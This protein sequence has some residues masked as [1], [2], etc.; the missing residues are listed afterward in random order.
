MGKIKKNCIHCGTVVERY[1]SQIL[2]T[3]YCSRACRSEYHKKYHTE[4]F[5]CHF[6]GKEKRVRKANFNYSGNNFCSRKCKDEWQKTGLK[7]EANPFYNKQHT[8]ETRIK[9]SKTKKSMNLTGE[10]AHNYNT[11]AVECSECGKVT[12]KIGY[13]LKRSKFHFC[14]IECHGKWKSKYN[15]GENNPN[16]NP[17]LTEFERER[18]RHIPG[19][20]EFVRNVLERDDFTCDICRQKGG[21]LNAHHLNG[22]D[23]DKGNRTNIDNGITLCEKCHTDFHKI[24]GYGNNTK[25]QYI[26]YK[27]TFKV[28]EKESV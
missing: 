17:E 8:I 26:D 27:N 18:E 5:N 11:H 6:C 22:Y 1:P 9:V 7:G 2:G 15:V 23:W 4:V 28:K 16:W 10:R 20:S 3:V 12:F 21:N 25:E 19:Y 24:Y 14:S 13:L